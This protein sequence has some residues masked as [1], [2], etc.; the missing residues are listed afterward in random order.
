V[1]KPYVLEYFP[2]EM[3]ILQGLADFFDANRASYDL[4]P[5]GFREVSGRSTCR[6]SKSIW[7]R[8]TIATGTFVGC[9]RPA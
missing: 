1:L 4:P 5:V 3:R 8:P 6:R 2:E 7:P 9:E